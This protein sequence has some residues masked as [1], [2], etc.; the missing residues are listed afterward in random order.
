MASRLLRREPRRGRRD[1]LRS[2]ELHGHQQR[3]VLSTQRDHSHRQ[4]NIHENSKGAT[5]SYQEGSE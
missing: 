1:G 3:W 2:G 5:W 4:V